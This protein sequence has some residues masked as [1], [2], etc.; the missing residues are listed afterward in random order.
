MYVL[1]FWWNSPF[2]LTCGLVN[3]SVK[4]LTL[5]VHGYFMHAACRDI[6]EGEVSDSM[7]HLVLS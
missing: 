7:A 5:T 4:N 2:W 1:F 3:L 6:Q